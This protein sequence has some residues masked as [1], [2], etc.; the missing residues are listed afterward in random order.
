[1]TIQVNEAVDVATD[2]PVTTETP[3]KQRPYTVGY[4]NRRRL[5]D[6]AS[7]GFTHVDLRGRDVRDLRMN[8]PDAPIHLYRNPEPGVATITLDE[9]RNQIDICTRIYFAEQRKEE[10]EKEKAQRPVKASPQRERPI[11][12]ASPFAVLATMAI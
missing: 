7:R 10:A 12:P 11:N 4:I 9:A 8:T 2:A 1:M 3:K 6:L 5:N